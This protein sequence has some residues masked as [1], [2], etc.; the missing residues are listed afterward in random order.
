MPT[1]FFVLLVLLLV[2]DVCGPCVDYKGE[3]ERGGL[4]VPY[5]V[6]W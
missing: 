2:G 6:L 4:A 1:F 3:G 5:T